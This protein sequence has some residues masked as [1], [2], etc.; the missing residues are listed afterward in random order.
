MM[1]K[2]RADMEAKGNLSDEQID[3]AMTIAGKFMNGPIM[4]AGVILGTI[5]FGFILSLVVSAILKHSKPEFE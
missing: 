5:F 4:L 2:A 1:D 3:Q